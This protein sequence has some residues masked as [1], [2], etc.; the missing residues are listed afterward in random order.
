MKIKVNNDILVWARQELNITQEEVADRMGRNIEDIVNWE[1]GKD[2]P[3]YAQLEKLAYTIY[4]RP[5]AVFFFPNIPNIPKNNGKFRTLD[6][7]IFNEIP[8]RIIEL[9]N[10]ARVM[11]LNLQELDSNSRIRITEL[12][13][14]EQNF[15]EKLRDVLGVDIELQKKAKNMSDAFEMWRSAFYECGVYVFKEAFKDNSFS[16]FCLYDIKYPVIYINNSMSY[17]RQIFTLFHELC[18]ILIKTSGIDKADDDYISRLELDNRKLEMICNMFAGK[19]LVPTNDLLKLIDNVEIN[20]KNIEKLSKKY[21]V[22]RDVILRKLLDIGKISKEAYEKKHSDYQDEM[23]RKPINNGGGN[24]YNTKKAYLGENYINDVCSNYYS[25]KIDLYE[26]ANYLNVRVEAIP[27]LG[28]MI[29]EG[30]R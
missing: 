20:E 19:F 24:Y 22:S 21:S 26:T 8:T 18:H 12:D 13:I 10:Q 5:L 25:G 15:Y 1:E 4:K 30:S 3:T 11:Q 17:S 6:N 27:Q 28:V 23:Y 16:G 2:Y 9:M 29:K 14:H 7:E